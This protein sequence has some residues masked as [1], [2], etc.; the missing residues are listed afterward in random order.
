MARA[1]VRWEIRELI[2][3]LRAHSEQLLLPVRLF[4]FLRA[5]PHTSY[6]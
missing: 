3:P 2:A 6:M 4:T 5:W 1:V